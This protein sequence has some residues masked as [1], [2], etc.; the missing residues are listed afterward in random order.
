MPG[1]VTLNTPI[2]EL[3]RHNIARLGQILSGK[4]AQALAGT[5]NNKSAQDVSV[6]DLLSYLPMRYEDRSNLAR[7]R[8][9][10]PGVEASLELYVKL[11]GGY[12]VR[13]KRSLR[14]SLYIFEISA[15]DL[16]RTGRPVVIWM[17]LSGP[18]AQQ[19]ITSYTRRFERGVR[20][21]AY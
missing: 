9:L 3:Y 2:N 19:I 8:D 20:F 14:Q 12:Q 1:P 15:T 5:S 18:H 13:N 7:I 17:F 21:V 10:Q 6:E 4:L 16:E 11:A